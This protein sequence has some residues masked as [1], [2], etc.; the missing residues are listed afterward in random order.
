MFHK[1][2]K[3]DLIITGNFDAGLS[4]ALATAFK[5]NLGSK[6]GK[7]QKV[8]KIVVRKLVQ[9]KEKNVFLFNKSKSAQNSILHTSI[10]G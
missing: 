8:R 2:S 5:S 3:V 9:L 4:G 1:I 10:L 7:K 6:I